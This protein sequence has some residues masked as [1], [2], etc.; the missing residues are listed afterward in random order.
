MKSCIHLM[1]SIFILTS[2]G[3]CQ[4]GVT[5]PETAMAANKFLQFINCEKTVESIR[6]FEANALSPN[7]AKIPIAHLFRLHG[8][9]FILMS[10]SRDLTPVKAYS[11]SGDF[12]TLPPSIKNFLLSESEY[13]IRIIAATVQRQ[14]VSLSATQRSWAFLLGEEYVRSASAYAVG[15]NLLTTSWNQR[16][17]Y[18]RYLPKLDGQ[19]VLVGCTNV[20]IAQ[21]MRY[22]RH[23]SFGNGVRTH[24]WN[25]EILKAIYSRTYNWNNMP[26]SIDG[27]HRDDQIDEVALLLLDLG[28]ANSTDFS[29]TGSGASINIET[30]IENFGYAAPILEMDNSNVNEFFTTLRAEI[31]ALR[32]VLLRFPNHSTVAD[33]YSSDPTGRKIHVNLGWGG[34]YDDFYYLDETV[35]AGGYTFSPNL[36]IYYNIRPCSEDNCCPNLEV[37]DKAER[38]HLIG[39]FDYEKDGDIYTCNLK[40]NTT[41]SGT[42]GY[43]NQAFFISVYDSYHHPLASGDSAISL[44]DL[45]AGRYYVRVSLCGTDGVCYSKSSGYENYTVDI[46]T[47]TLTTEEKIVAESSLDKPP[48]FGETLRDI[49]ISP[50]Q[51]QSYRFIVDVRDENGDV[52]VLSIGVTNPYAVQCSID[53]NLLALNVNHGGVGKAARVYVQATVGDQTTQT[54]F[55]VLVSDD[56]CGFGKEFQI[57][58]NFESQADFNTHRVVLDGNCTI[59]GYN[60]YSNQA[61]FTT[62]LD[63]LQR[64]LVVPGDDPISRYFSAGVYGIG[65]SLSQNFGGTGIYYPFEPGDHASYILTVICP[66]SDDRIE[67]VANMLRVDTN[68]LESPSEDMQSGGYDITSEL[69]CKA[70]LHV[71]DSPVILK[72]NMV[73]ADLTPSGDQV[74]SGYFYA[75]PNDFAYGSI[76]NPELF[77][78]IYIAA[79][80]WCNIAFNHVTVDPVTVYSAHQ[81]SGTA[82]QTGRA[83]IDSR[84]MQH[85][86]TGVAIDTSKQSSGDLSGTGSAAGYDLGSSLWSQA[87]LQ[88]P[89]NPVALVWKQVGTDITPSGAKVVS[90][91]FYADPADFAYGSQFNPEVFVKVYIDPTG[92]T[93]MAFNHVTVD[94]VSIDSAHGYAGTAQKS[95]SA[96]LDSR[97]LQHEYTGV[98]VQ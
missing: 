69:R 17:P 88:V 73:G 67:T 3:L 32:P 94:P 28:I 23:P 42:I 24:V 26:E 86:Y 40:G 13:N 91:Y 39:R 70:I 36:Y 53:G 7:S 9:G 25:G 93:N 89:G 83:T 64:T 87:V 19:K 62:I 48:V 44:K 1:I 49:V 80:G 60:G 72:W 16:E 8:G 11:L 5:K 4:A 50:N 68:G 96:T 57:N 43:Y 75:D 76:Y 34:H 98:S 47:R 6:V 18:N 27:S 59:C 2:Q 14:S 71:P 61:F 15:T 82:D 37:G 66:D 81:F 52:P 65:T 12:E 56:P 58:G 29:L 77:A 33:G 46:S 90:G 31:D 10:L 22:H 79:N 95:G 84:L 41:L 38:L 74:I 21:V 55:A 30:L 63:S 35:V 78:K 20:A 97:L 85:E 92:W 45:P 54:S 51:S